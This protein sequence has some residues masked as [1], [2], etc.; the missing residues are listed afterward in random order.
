MSVEEQKI[1]KD[2]REAY[3]K[4]KISPQRREGGVTEQR[5]ASER[6]NTHMCTLIDKHTT[7]KKQ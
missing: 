2:N 7:E 5:G 1:I 3:V 6:S 4:C